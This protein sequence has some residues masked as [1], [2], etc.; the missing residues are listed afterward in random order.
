MTLSKHTKTNIVVEF[1]LV[2]RVLKRF[3]AGCYAWMPLFRFKY[4]YHTRMCVQ[5][6]NITTYIYDFVIKKSYLDDLTK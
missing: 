6:Y 3:T 2:L 1:E 5:K 4:I